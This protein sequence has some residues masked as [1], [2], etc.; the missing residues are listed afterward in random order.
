MTSRWIVI[1]A[2][3]TVLLGTQGCAGAGLTLFGAGAGVSGGTGVSY[4]LDSVAYKTFTAPVEDLQGATL[5]ALK[6]MEI[7][8]KENKAGESGNGRRIVAVASDRTIEI[9]L[10]RLTTKVSRMRV[11]AK[12]GWF[13]RD[14]AT[15]TEIIV[16]T[17]QTLE[18]HT[19]RANKAMPTAAHDS[20]K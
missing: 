7:T 20:P 19:P 6:R 5:K 17:A 16:Q 13:W 4:T 8:I 18:D 1:G 11:N 15:A 12:Q 3:A 14:R 2:M 10:D 9:E